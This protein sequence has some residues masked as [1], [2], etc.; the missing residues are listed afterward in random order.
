MNADKDFLLF[1][2]KWRNTMHTNYIYYGKD[3][4]Y[5]FGHAHFKFEN[6]KIVKWYDPF[7]PSPR[8]YFYLIGNL[9]DIWAVLIRSIKYD[10]IIEYPDPE[11]D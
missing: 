4:E 1:L 7:E 5:K 9:K 3:Y 6:G 11:Q 8:L 2:G 10:K